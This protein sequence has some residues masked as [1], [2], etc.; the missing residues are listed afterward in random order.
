MLR[1]FA[2]SR[3]A[4]RLVFLLLLITGLAG[5]GGNCQSPGAATQQFPPAELQRELSFR[6]GRL[7]KSVTPAA[8]LLERAYR[9]KAALL[10][11]SSLPS[12]SS[13]SLPQESAWTPLG[14]EPL[15]S[16][17]SGELGE[18]DYGPVA[19]RVTAVAVDPNDPTGNTVYIG[20]ANGG[21]WK[22]SNAAAAD[23]A[24]VI[25]T[26]LTDRGATL[27]TGT[28]AVHPRNPQIILVGTGEANLA[29]DSY[30]GL[31][32]LRTSDGGAHWTLISAADSNHTPFAGLGFSR[33][34]FSTAAP[35]LVAAGASNFNFYPGASSSGQGLYYSSDSGV[36]W[37]SASVKDGSVITTRSSVTDM[38]FNAARGRFFAALAWHGIYSSSDGVNWSR[39][40]N[41]PGGS[42]LSTAAC[43]ASG[44][45]TCPILRAG[46][47][48]HPTKDEM[49]VW[50]ISGDPST[51][52]FADQGIWKS[53]DTGATWTAIS[54]SGI[55]N[56]GDFDGCGAAQGWYS[57][58][59]TA[60]ANGS[61][62]TDLYAGTT[63]LYKC[64][65]SASNSDCASRPFINLTHAYGCVP[66]G[67]FSHVHPNQHAISYMVADTGKAVMYFGNDGGIYRALDGYEL[68]SGTCGETPNAF[69]SL[70]GTLG[71]LA[72]LV[73]LS[74]HASEAGTL[75]AGAQG[76]GS[77]ATD[78]SHSGNNG[79]TWIAVNKGE[80]G[81][82]AINPN[83]TSQWFTSAAGVS[84]QSCSKRINCLAQDFQVV[85]SSA[86]LGGDAGGFVTPYLL[87]RQA[88]N[89]MLVGTCRVWRGNNDGSGF[90]AL[91][92]NF[93][94]GSNSVCS[95]AEDN[96]IS[97]LASGGTPLGAGGSPVVYAGTAAGRILVTTNA[98]GGPETWYEATPPETGY[99]ISSLALDET[100]SSGKTAYASVMG[101][102]VPHVWKTTDA[103]LS[104]SNV[105]GNLPDAP[106]DSLL[107]DPDNHQLVYAGSDVGVFSA[108][109]KT[110]SNVSWQQV[111]PLSAGRLLPNVPVTT[112]A[113]F[114]SSAL[115]A[116]RAATYGRGAWELVLASSGPDYSIALTN[117]MLMLF[118]GQA[119]SFTGELTALYGYSSP[120]VV[121]CEAGTLPDACWG[122][123]VTPTRGGTAFT[124][125]ARH[126][127]VRDFNFNILATGT[128]SNTTVHR[129]AASLRVV[130]FG[131]TFAPGTPNPVTLT[132]NSGSSA[133]PVGLVVQALGSLQGTVNL[134]C[135]GLPAGATC[136]FYPSA[137]LSFTGGGTSAVTMVIAT[138]VSTPN[139]NAL[140]ITISAV[141]AGA[142]AAKTQTV[143]LNV[144][145]EPD[146]EVT[147]RP[148]SLTAHPGDTLTA[149]VT[150]AAVNS[151]QGTV[152]VSCGTS[153]LAGLQCSLS[154]NAVY[155]TNAPTGD[156][157]LTVR[158]PQTATAGSYTVSVDS[159]DLSGTPTHASLV[160]LTVVPDFVIH[161]PKATVSV[162]QGGTATYA[163]QVSALGGAFT[164][165][166]SFSCTGLPKNTSYSF[167]PSVV[168]PGSGTT[169]VTLNVRT[170]TVVAGLRWR[171]DRPSWWMAMLLPMIG[172]SLFARA[173]GQR[174]RFLL[175]LVLA[176]VCSLAVLSA[177][178]GG[179]GGGSPPIVPP[180]DT[181]TPVGTYTLTVTA[182]SGAVS[183]STD[184][185]LIVQ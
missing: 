120:V 150:L 24:A 56:C 97:A 100:D 183:H 76:N 18:Q 65:V 3:L 132:A 146:Y 4:R 171:N 38:A 123:T 111:G 37:H 75:L 121:S 29:L 94:T 126:G 66:A 14:P 74:Q 96:L 22:S 57:L 184:L 113:M 130:D 85:V 137:A 157:T 83:N 54:E 60:V 82:T 175:G 166:I 136:G 64:T 87:D 81:Y 102:G 168:V 172:G 119:G 162:S 107:I 15:L 138:S 61:S 33:I 20:G 80:G 147:F 79:V 173:G 129:A 48:I 181:A 149:R 46:I 31:G 92:Y 7:S 45:S 41:Q 110:G 127:S 151:Y 101:F 77:A 161:L 170:S 155:L 26:P 118:P 164:G 133:G 9:Q 185:T 32:I 34:A 89:R 174:R 159:H 86:T 23:S 70:N 13:W 10:R 135:S 143:L 103:G 47:A 156:V 144:K 90:A 99:P 154:A 25:W 53:T 50:Y 117:S 178:G 62:A 125:T 44:A 169:T 59:L 158:V 43:P 35:N 106:A 148:A 55:E 72:T 139:T 49:Y 105:T 51:G 165:P 2:G 124:V 19:G 12:A 179:N 11:N 109:I 36:T 176:A 17:A 108:E 163:L 115:K 98:A 95:G 69:A 88:S 131:L 5:A 27:S 71:S 141:I 40:T 128:D 116:L 16:N 91:S 140:P 67:S 93:D 104:W 30:Y 42:V 177:C 73:S 145:N 142:P 68:S 52:E 152:A 114:K 167:T 39:L 134:S 63:N 180:P 1:S 58:E 8:K 160:T 78:V 122:E 21:V 84:I 182:I 6:R 112:L 28:I 153:Y